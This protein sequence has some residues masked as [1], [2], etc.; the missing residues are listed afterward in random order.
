[1]HKK[2]IFSKQ[3]FTIVEYYDEE[4]TQMFLSKE[5]LKNYTLTEKS[6]KHDNKGW[7]H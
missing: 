2:G 1:M 3:W 5:K 7:I 4:G 6:K